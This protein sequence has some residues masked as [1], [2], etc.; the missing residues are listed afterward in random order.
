MTWGDLFCGGGGT[1]TGALGVP[2]VKVLWALNHSPSAIATHMANHPET[3]HYQSDILEQDESDLAPVDGIWMSSECVNF[4]NA[5][6][7][8]LLDQGS[9]SLPMELIRF[10]KRCAPKI[11]I[12]EN[13]K[14]FMSW[15][16]L[17]NGRPDKKR[18]GES[19]REWVSAVQ[20]C[21]Y[22]NYEHKVINAADYGAYTSRSRYFGI[23]TQPGIEISWPEQTHS[24]TGGDGYIKWNPCKDKLDLGN[25]GKS[26]FEKKLCRNTIKRIEAGLK[27]YGGDPFILSFYGSDGKFNGCSLDDPLPTITTKDRHMVVNPPG[28]IQFICS[29]YSSDKPEHMSHGIDSPIPT[30]TTSHAHMLVTQFLQMS[31]NSDGN[32]GSQI[33]D[34]DSPSPTITNTNK[35]ALVT[36]TPGCGKNINGDV[37]FRFIT[38][39]E[40]TALQGFPDGYVLLGTKAEQLRHIGNSVV[41]LVAMRLIEANYA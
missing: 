33:R 19:F 37:F 35:I 29:Q 3:V 16:P 6:G 9:R 32:P 23:F 12:V 10:V 13:V 36:Q 34:I 7:G 31:Y 30:L 24:K 15:G 2:G 28:K 17:D 26:I 4:S 18:K 38:I 25:L 20:G 1:T 8:K 40:A 22:P 41:P 39:D 21:G 5:K 11:I 14:E 27:K